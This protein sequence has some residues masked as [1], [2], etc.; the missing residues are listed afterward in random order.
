MVRL[1]KQTNLTDLVPIHRLDRETAG[2]VLFSHNPRTRG[3]YTAL[4]RERKI[5]KVY[6]ALAP[7]T[8]KFQGLS[9]P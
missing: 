8:D 2:V 7:A 9:F 6:H 4:F 3:Y 1:R 5:R